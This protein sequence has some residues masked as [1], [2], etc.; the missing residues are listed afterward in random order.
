MYS[1]QFHEG[2]AIAYIEEKRSKYKYGYI[3]LKGELII[4]FQ[5]E[6][7]ENFKKGLGCIQSSENKKWGAVNKSGELI[8]TCKFLNSFYFDN[9]VAVANENYDL[10][11]SD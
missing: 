11:W 6:G 9:Q 5:Y 10:I 2:L 4:P 7:A 8:I 1:G 3:D